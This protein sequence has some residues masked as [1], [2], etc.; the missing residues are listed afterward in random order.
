MPVSAARASTRSMI[1]PPWPAPH[2]SSVNRGRLRDSD[3][4]LQR[5]SFSS[6]DPSK[7]SRNL[8]LCEDRSHSTRV[9]ETQTAEARRAI[10]RISAAKYRPGLRYDLG[11]SRSRSADGDRTRAESNIECSVIA[12]QCRRDIQQAGQRRDQ[13]LVD[14]HGA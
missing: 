3:H 9:L 8:F 2:P 7:S 6:T 12:E 11:R 4:D 13:G 14:A 5:S 1:P 10:G